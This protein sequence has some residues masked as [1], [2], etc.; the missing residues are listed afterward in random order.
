MKRSGI[1]VISTLAIAVV[2]S[3]YA[4][5]LVVLIFG[6]RD[7]SLVT[8]WESWDGEAQVSLISSVITAMG[9][10]TSAIILPFVF[11]DRISS[12]TDM[13]DRTERDLAS[14][15]LTTT[16]K[17]DDLTAGFE[18]QLKS[19]QEATEA[20]AEE[21]N[22]LV[23]ALYAA[24]TTLLGQGQVTDSAH[25]QKIVDS[26]WEKAKFAC[27]DRLANKKYMWAVTRENISQMRQMTDEYFSALVTN[28]VIS[29]QERGTLELLR[30]LRYARAHPAPAE[31]GVVR[32]LQT[33]IDD[34]SRSDE[35]NGGAAVPEK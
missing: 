7:G 35:L 34:F 23:S 9:L 31:F 25:A 21:S 19:M 27:R 3:L 24:V 33:K 4:V 28:N 10:V 13:V 5:I 17:L 6:I 20:K 18:K 16:S 8:L 22:E 11:R 2:L 14:L 15:N 26:L 30:R 29:P 12:L 1:G 32:E